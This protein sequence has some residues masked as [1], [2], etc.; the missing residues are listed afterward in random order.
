MRKHF[1]QDELDDI[2]YGDSEYELV[3]S[4]FLEERRWYTVYW[5][6]F[7]YPTEGLLGFEH[8]RP[9]TEIQ[10]G[11]DTDHSQPVPVIPKT[12]EVVTYV[13]A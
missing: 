1:Q 10:E 5:V 13:P 3:H 2:G 6:V 4:E 12:V 7:R 8:T 11:Q 9:S